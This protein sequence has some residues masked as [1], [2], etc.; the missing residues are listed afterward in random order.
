M[1]NL[2]ALTTATVLAATVATASFAAQ[3]GGFIDTAEK[4]SA[5]Q[6]LN[7]DLVNASSAAVLEVYTLTNGAADQLVSSRDLAAGVHTDLRLS[8]PKTPTADLIAV[9]KI[10]DQVVDSQIIELN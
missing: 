10:N 5:S 9:L 8:S 7:I 4:I 6:G 1:K 3:S 2:F